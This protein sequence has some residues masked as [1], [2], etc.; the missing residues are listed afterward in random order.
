MNFAP[1]L[2]NEDSFMI[3]PNEFVKDHELT[4]KEITASMTP[5]PEYERRLK[6]KYGWRD[7]MSIIDRIKRFISRSRKD[8][9][10]RLKSRLNWLLGRRLSSIWT[11]QYTYSI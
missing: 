6:A 7:K 8:K 4:Q 11:A 3:I 2:E 9:I 5:D 1:G 10:F